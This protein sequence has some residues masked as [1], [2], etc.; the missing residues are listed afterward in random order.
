[1]KCPEAVEWIHRYLDGDLSEEEV[2][3][4]KEHL[5]SCDDCARTYD[6]LKQLSDNLYQLPEVTPKF[7]IVDSILPRLDEIDRARDEEGSTLEVSE[8]EVPLMKSIPSR[9][10]KER[11]PFWRTRTAVPAALGTAAAVILG[12]FIYQY[13]P[14]TIPNAEIAPTSQQT[15]LKKD[16]QNSSSAGAEVST[17]VDPGAADS[18]PTPKD[19]SKQS[20]EPSTD[21]VK[22]NAEVQGD[23]KQ[24]GADHAATR[25]EKEGAAPPVSHKSDTKKSGSPEK[26][27]TDGD[28]E[29][30]SQVTEQDKSAASGSSGNRSMDQ[31]KVDGTQTKQSGQDK[32]VVNKDKSPEK[33]QEKIPLAPDN[34]GFMGIMS[35]SPIKLSPDGKYVAEVEQDHLKVYLNNTDDR[36]LL[37]DITLNGNWVKGEWSEDSKTFS[38]QTSLDD[39]VKDYTYTVENNEDKTNSTNLSQ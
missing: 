2:T 11:T 4:L 29:F 16:T 27:T 1:M 33:T 22:K 34:N 38:Y 5:R 39:T 12:I 15:Q 28:K 8:T 7:S 3:R 9:S 17:Q 30:T 23:A 25:T 36:T 35:S 37:S 18:D 10:K 14:E 6:V 13:Q 32:S 19:S 20:S 31:K 26:T 24:G 21:G